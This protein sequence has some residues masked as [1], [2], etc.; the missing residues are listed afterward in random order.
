MSAQVSG[1]NFFT[2]DWEWNFQKHW[3]S[4]R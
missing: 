2:W 1:Y 3:H 4:S